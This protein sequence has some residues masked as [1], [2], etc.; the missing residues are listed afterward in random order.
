APVSGNMEP[1]I[2]YAAAISVGT[3]PTFGDEQRS[4]ESFVLDRDADL[5]GH[6]VKVEFVDHVRTMEKFDSVEQLLDVMAKDVIK[7]R[8]I[9]QEDLAAQ[10]MESTTYFLQ[11]ESA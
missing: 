1:E 2:A 3:N 6:D 5:Y 11:S 7:T 4:V 8:K 10:L 9:L